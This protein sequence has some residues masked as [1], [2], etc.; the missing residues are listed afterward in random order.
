MEKE[1][2]SGRK[3]GVATREGGRAAVG[4]DGEDS[5]EWARLSRRHTS[6]TSGT[7]KDAAVERE[8]TWTAMSKAE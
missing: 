3:E 2:C 4:G 1:T 8:T 7:E 5:V 6:S